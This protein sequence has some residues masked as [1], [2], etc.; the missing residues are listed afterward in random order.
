MERGAWRSH[1]VTRVEALSDA[2]FA[3][4]VALLIVSLEVPQTFTELWARMQGFV[5]FA[6]SF[7]VLFQ[8]W[9]TQHIFFRRYGLQDGLTVSLNGVLLFLVLF[10]MYPLKFVFSL[11]VSEMTGGGGLVHLPGGR[12]EAMVENAG[13]GTILMAVYSLGFGAVFGIFA[14]LYF[15]ALRKR[16]ELELTDAE[17]FDARA[18]IEH[19]LLMVAV[20][21]LSIGVLFAFDSSGWAGFTYMLIGPVLTVH[22]TWRG[23]QRRRLYEEPAR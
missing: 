10:Y 23:K 19:N 4:A 6:I 14:L 8:V 17:V 3:F 22:G 18:S 21:A 20:A 16:G 2:V 13:Q 15:R 1:E 9:Y 12:V 7:A 5:A 11:L